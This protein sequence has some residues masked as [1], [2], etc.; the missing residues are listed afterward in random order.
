MFH[1][2][3]EYHG[4]SGLRSD[5]FVFIFGFVWFMIKSQMNLKLIKQQFRHGTYIFK[6]HYCD[7][8]AS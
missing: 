3:S 7:R 6:A 4:F 8:F 2:Y 5:P 1:F